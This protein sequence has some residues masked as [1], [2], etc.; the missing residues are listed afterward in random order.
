MPSALI[1]GAS[2][3]I[4][5]ALAMEL[6]GRGWDLG[7]MARRVDRMQTLAASIQARYPG[8]RVEVRALDVGDIA[9][10]KTVVTD[11]MDTLED[12]RWVV[13]NAGVGST[14]GSDIDQI[15]TMIDTNLMGAIATI[16]TAASWF[17]VH[18]TSGHEPHRTVVGISSV[19]GFRGLPQNPTYSATKAGLTAYLEGRRVTLTPLGVRV[20]DI[21]P[22][23]IA[24][25]ITAGI[26]RPAQI[27]AARA[28]KTMADRIESGAYQAVVPAI[29]WRAIKPVMRLMP[30]KAFAAI[31]GRL[32]D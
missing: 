31:V 1:T 9:A 24:T 7:L 21:A 30:G 20:V 6:A 25:E 10:V 2:S 11:L 28:A 8:R 29:P 18:P 17:E 5:E 32:G 26:P 12:P 4:G 13:A 19:A 27:S 22:G 16:E 14:T 23:F 15:K 3:G